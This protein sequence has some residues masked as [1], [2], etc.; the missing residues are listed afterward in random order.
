L[1]PHIYKNAKSLDLFP[2]EKFTGK[3]LVITCI[4]MK[5]ISLEYLRML[6]DEIRTVDFILFTRDG[7]IN[8]IPLNTLRIARS[9]PVKQ[10]NG[11]QPST[12]RGSGVILF[13]STTLSPPITIEKIVE[14][15]DMGQAVLCPLTG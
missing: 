12:L 11:W 2:P 6:E 7:R 15:L 3:A 9:Q 14:I 5:E 13:P 1:H 4:A 8:G 10:Q